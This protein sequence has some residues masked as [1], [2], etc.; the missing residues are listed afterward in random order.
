MISKIR[1]SPFTCSLPPQGR[2]K[3]TRGK[4]SVVR[5]RDLG[6]GLA[7]LYDHSI[8]EVKGAESAIGNDN[9]IQNRSTP[10]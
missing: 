3:G 2:K 1:Q 7:G 10:E 4:D 5:D 9:H 6:L 8:H